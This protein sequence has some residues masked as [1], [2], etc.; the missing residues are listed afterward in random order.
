MGGGIWVG[1]GV[2]LEEAIRTRGPEAPTLGRRVLGCR[3]HHHLTLPRLFPPG[4]R[5]GASV[6]PQQRGGAGAA[7]ISKSPAGC[8]LERRG[9]S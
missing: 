4:S 7:L 5:L 8:A 6:S 9:R 3:I 2:A 1:V